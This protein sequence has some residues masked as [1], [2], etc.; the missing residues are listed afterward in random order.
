MAM[1]GAFVLQMQ[2]LSDAS[3]VISSLNIAGHVGYQSGFEKRIPF[4]VDGLD[5]IK[6]ECERLR[7]DAAKW[8]K[9]VKECRSDFFFLNYFTMREIL[10]LRLAVLGLGE[11]EEEVA[12]IH[13]SW[14]CKAAAHEDAV[15]QV[16]SR[17]GISRSWAIVCLH[18]SQFDVAAAGTY[19]LSNA[20]KFERIV[21]EELP[22]ILSTLTDIPVADHQHGT[23]LLADPVAL[24]LSML[25]QLSREGG[26]NSGTAETGIAKWRERLN[27]G[28]PILLSLGQLLRDIMRDV[29]AAVRLLDGVEM[30]EDSVY[31]ILGLS[32]LTDSSV[33]HR[34]DMLYLGEG[35]E[36]RL[37]VF[38]CSVESAQVIN[39]VLSVYVRRDRLPEAGEV[40]FCTPDTSMEEVDLLLMRFSAAKANNRGSNVYCIADVHKLSYAQQISLVKHMRELLEERGLRSVAT[41]VIVSGDQNQAILNVLSSQLVEL[42]ALVQ[43]PLREACAAA[44]ERHCGETR[45]V[46]SEVNGGG[47]SAWILRQ[48]AEGQKHEAIAYIRVPIR[49]ATTARD[50]ID[51]FSQ[52]HREHPHRIAFHVDIGHVIPSTANTMLFQL[53]ILGVLR[54]PF[55]CRVYQRRQEDVVF[56][57]IPNSLNNKTAIALHV[58]HLF[59][60][61]ILGVREHSMMLD[62]PIFSADPSQLLIQPIEELQYVCKYLRA[63]A[64]NR[65]YKDTPR[66]TFGLSFSPNDVSEQ[67]VPA[68]ECFA[69]LRQC[70]GIE[71]ED[72]KDSWSAV[73][74]FVQFAYRQLGG[75]E[76]YPMVKNGICDEPQWAFVPS[77]RE[78]SACKRQAD[79]DPSF[80]PKTCLR[81]HP[82]PEY[83]MSSLPVYQSTGDT[84]MYRK[85]QVIMNDT[86]SFRRCLLRLL[87]ATAKESSPEQLCRRGTR[88]LE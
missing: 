87:V 1:I 52:A 11:A 40:L 73:H 6:L 9:A 4:V 78:G 24:F 83:P 38:V 22:G 64:A 2:A 29:R 28:E 84:C 61:Q 20:L 68:K 46:A 85:K 76:E 59:P 63:I 7:C 44:F 32:S 79:N 37:P 54:D 42:P 18:A 69:L 16:A 71:D 88:A 77:G 81:H 57:E 41:L 27:A 80:F 35:E 49:E 21:A 48:V 10:R 30:A 58:C 74:T 65:F 86:S 43:R 53:L 45:C 34:A 19:L 50:L 75:I 26:I 62:S 55:S 15:E 31:R 36:K 60:N 12:R 51:M 5:E 23:V 67:P 82:D 14:V 13:N 33:D 25:R 39:I 72:T 47:K 70:R 3:D 66:S 8:E 17:N 56:V